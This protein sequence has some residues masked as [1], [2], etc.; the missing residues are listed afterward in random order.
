MY[1]VFV[2]HKEIILTAIPPTS[3]KHKVLPLAET[4]F[5]DILKVFKTTKVKKLYLVH[6]DPDS[7]MHLFKQK[8]KVTVAGGGV[9]RNHKNELLF[10]FRKKKW[11][12]PKG[13]IEKNESLEAGA[14][15]EVKEETGVKQLRLGALA[16][17]TF[18]IFKRN[19]QYQ[20]KET[21]W[22]F[23]DTA[24]AGPLSPETKEGISKAVWKN[25]KKTIKALEKTYPNIK[26][27]FEKINLPKSSPEQE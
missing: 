6:H 20:L 16:G 11:D 3:G 17:K 25:D 12:L 23:M 1:K 22:F 5:A 2:N 26:R 13:R 24:Y 10:I 27:L 7:L 9:V 8:I 18:H 4:S 15:R 21:Y 14:K 19:D